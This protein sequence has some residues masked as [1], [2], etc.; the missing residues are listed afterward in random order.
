MEEYKKSFIQSELKYIHNLQ[1]QA[2]D[3]KKL[4]KDLYQLMIL[5]TV[6]DWSCYYDIDNSWKQILI[7]AI[8]KII[9][10][11]S[12]LI[13]IG[14]TNKYYSNVNAP[15]GLYDWYE[16]S[17]DLN[18]IDVSVDDTKSVT[19]V[20][21]NYSE[22]LGGELILNDFKYVLVSDKILH[23]KFVELNKP[24][25]GTIK[26][27]K[28]TQV[29]K[30][31]GK[32]QWVWVQVSDPGEQHFSKMLDLKVQMG[33]KLISVPK[34]WNIVIPRVTDSIYINLM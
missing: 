6:L 27:Y 5:L 14:F 10:S 8:K 28:Y 29:P 15:Q 22:I 9:N 32:Y 26:V 17:Q 25:S 2:F 18:L 13:P 20:S 24:F 19:T 4:R 21:S 7:T 1:Y 16:T 3:D 11:N 31:G 23:N 12:Q 33:D 34:S 30:P